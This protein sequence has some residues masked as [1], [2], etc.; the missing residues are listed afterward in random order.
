MSSF[1][2]SVVSGAPLFLEDRVPFVETAIED[3]TN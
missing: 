3:K 2:S 1:S